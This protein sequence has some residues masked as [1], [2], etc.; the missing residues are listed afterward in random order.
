MHCPRTFDSSQAGILVRFL[1]LELSSLWALALE[2]V[3]FCKDTANVHCRRC[4]LGVMCSWCDSNNCRSDSTNIFAVRWCTV[5]TRL[6][7]GGSLLARGCFLA[8]KIWHRRSCWSVQFLTRVSN[9]VSV[10][11]VFREN[12]EDTWGLSS[13]TCAKQASEPSYILWSTILA[14]MFALL[15]LIFHLPTL[16]PWVEVWNRVHPIQSSERVLWPSMLR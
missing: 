5:A 13:P 4:G 16:W 6:P 7:R 12:V 2:C 1:L 8:G 15:G 9:S 10:I 11:F 3:P 14:W